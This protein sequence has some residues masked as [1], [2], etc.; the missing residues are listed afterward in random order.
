M[1]KTI[2]LSLVL[3]FIVSIIYSKKLGTLSDIV[4]PFSITIDSGNVYIVEGPKV[5][6]YSLKD[7]NFIKKFG[8]KGEGPEEFRTAPMTN[9]GNI[10]IDVYSEFIL[11]NSLGKLS[12]FSKDGKYQKEIRATG[13]WRSFKLLSKKFVGFGGIRR[14]ENI[15]FI[16]LKKYMIPY[17][18]KV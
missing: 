1:K 13:N 3:L 18:K 7:L 5:Y 16:S 11:V 14:E 6:I 9:M 12:Y 4:N 17:R 10:M 15:R 8:K 2:T